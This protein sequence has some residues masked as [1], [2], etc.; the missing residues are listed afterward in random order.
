MK[1]LAP[2]LCV[3]STFAGMPHT[4][5]AEPKES[6]VKEF[7]ETK[8]KAEA[9]DVNAE[10]KLA[11]MY[12][13]G[14]GTPKDD[15]IAV[16]WYRKVAA[17]NDARGQSMLGVMYTNARGVDRDYEVALQWFRKAAAQKSA[18][19][20]YNLGHMYA[21]GKGVPAD[22]KESAAWYRKAAEH[23]DLNSQRILGS[24]YAAGR[25]VPKDM[26]QAHAWTRV[27]APPEDAATLA[28]LKKFESEMTAEQIAE[29][30]KLAKEIAARVAPPKKP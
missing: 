28:Q 25:G 2:L 19:A 14:F 18:H 1:F 9:G 3:L 30:T 23:N 6:E 27:S 5:W 13:R 29:A 16:M 11:S 20:E 26:V 7:Q 8:T 22:E 24:L 10:Y 4:T 15:G 17:K 12:A 21:A